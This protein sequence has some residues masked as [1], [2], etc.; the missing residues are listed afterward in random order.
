[1]TT[2]ALA[3][4]RNASSAVIDRG[5]TLS[6]E[7]VAALVWDS[8][9]SALWVKRKMRAIAYKP[10]KE[11]YWYESDAIAFREKYLAENQRMAS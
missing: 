7:Q 9:V 2:R 10:G 1:M 6:A 3:I 5:R 8:R 4:T 11:L